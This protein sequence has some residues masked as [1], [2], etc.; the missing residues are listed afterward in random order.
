MTLGAT[1]SDPAAAVTIGFLGWIC[2]WSLSE[3]HII[4]ATCAASLTCIYMAVAIY[5]KIKE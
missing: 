3:I 1:G 2:S 5:K 4:A